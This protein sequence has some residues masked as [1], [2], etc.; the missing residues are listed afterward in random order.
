[1]S[2]RVFALKKKIYM[3]IRTFISNNFYEHIYTL[4][5]RKKRIHNFSKYKTMLSN[6]Y[7]LEIGGPS[8]IFK[9]K[10]PI[11]YYA[12]KIDGVNFASSTLWEKNLVDSGDFNYFMQRFGIQYISDATNLNK[13]NDLTYD[14][15]LSSHCLEHIANPLKALKEWSRVIKEDAYMVLVLPNKDGNFDRNRSFTKFDHILKDFEN[16][17]DESDLTHLDEIIELHDFEMDKNLGTLDEFVLRGKDNLKIRG[18]HHHVFDEVLIKEILKWCN[19]KVLDFDKDK[20]NFYTLAR[21]N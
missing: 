5:H 12:K 9:K 17:V 11:Y 13:I 20:T 14:F 10:I 7:G 1:M 6:K 4:Y 2:F 8:R 19:F 16:D 3:K 18:L 21:K 15:L